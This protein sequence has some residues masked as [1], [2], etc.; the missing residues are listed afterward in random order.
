MIKIDAKWLYNGHVYIQYQFLQQLWKNS[1]Y[2]WWL[3]NT[4]SFDGLN[5]TY[6]RG[7]VLS[8][9]T[10]GTD[11]YNYHYNSEGIRYKK[12]I[13]NAETIYGLDGNKII[14]E[15][16]ENNF[17]YLYEGNEII[18]IYDLD[19]FIRCFF[20]KDITG[21]IIS[22]VHNHV[23]V[24]RYKYDAYGLLATEATL[25]QFSNKISNYDKIDNTL[26][27]LISSSISVDMKNDKE[28]FKKAWNKIIDKI[29]SLFS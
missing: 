28:W 11:T 24:N 4:T 15:K 17:L 5:L 20:V 10:N 1:S 26:K 23:E 3:C 21:N 18:G 22:I 29:K 6:I 8:S 9:I 16:G 25:F 12:I 27:S 14:Y 2:I 7:S 13:N 19:A